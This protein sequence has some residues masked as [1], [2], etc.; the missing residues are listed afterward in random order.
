MCNLKYG[1]SDP[2]YKTE[3]DC[4]HGEQTCGCQEGWVGRGVEW[5]GSLGLV[6][7]KRY[8]WNGWARKPYSTAQGIL[9]LGRFA[10]QQKLKKHY[11][12]NN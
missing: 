1:T 11:K 8:I 6:D 7:A 12:L 5:T 3:T 10:I 4:G 9:C 2:I